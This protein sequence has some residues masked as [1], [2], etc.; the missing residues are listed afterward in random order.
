MTWANKAHSPVSAERDSLGGGGADLDREGR[1]VLTDMVAF[2]LIN[3]YV[4]NA[5]ERPDRPRQDF[6]CREAMP[7]GQVIVVGDMNIAPSPKDC[8]PS[9]PFDD[10]YSHREKELMG[11]FLADYVD[12][13]RHLHPDGQS[14]GYTCWEERT[15]ARNYNIGVRIDFVLV[16]KPLVPNLVSISIP[17]PDII[18]CKWSDH[19]PLLVE[20]R[21]IAPLLPHPPC[22][23]SSLKDRRFHDPSQRSI[24]MMFGAANGVKGS[25]VDRANGGVADEAKGGGVEKGKGRGV[26][27]A[28]GGGVEKGKGGGVDKAEGGGVDQVKDGQDVLCMARDKTD[29]S[30]QG[31]AS[32]SLGGG[33]PREEEDGDQQH[34]VP[35]TDGVDIDT[36]KL[37][38]NTAGTAKLPESTAGTTNPPESIGFTAK[39]P[40]NSAGTSKPP[41]SIAS[42]AKR[43]VAS[44]KLPPPKKKAAKGKNKK[45]GGG[46]VPGQRSIAAFFSAGPQK[47]GGGLG[48]RS[49][50]TFFSAG[51]Q[52]E[53][54]A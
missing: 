41:S 21:D 40:L 54:G 45:G 52:K 44:P 6:K 50:A 11:Q 38:L 51:P 14:E 47:E 39:P 15:N 20:L 46:L 28:E 27:K 8:H 4:P 24:K 5:G 1:M 2:V 16:S 9:I 26:D 3:V 23:L 32:T 13:Y 33:P 48:Q 30:T 25:V 35:T 34:G 10:L 7:Q 22:A 31:G 29:R 19:A 42:T 37:P 49:I 43:R 12:V 53:G 36:A 17:P 18:P